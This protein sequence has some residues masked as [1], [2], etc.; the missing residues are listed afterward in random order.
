MKNL[1]FQ[2]DFHFRMKIKFEI[3]QIPVTKA[4]EIFTIRL[5]RK[6]WLQ[7]EI[8]EFFLQH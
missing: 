4:H 2:K 5:F 7:E 6:I 1:N 3:S 8:I